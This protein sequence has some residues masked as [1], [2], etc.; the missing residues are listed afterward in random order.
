MKVIFD[1]FTQ[2]KNEIISGFAI[3]MYSILEC[4]L[5]KTTRIK[6]SSMLELILNVIKKPFERGKK[7]QI[8][9]T[10]LGTVGNFEL[11]LE[12]GKLVIITKASYD[13]GGVDGSLNLSVD[14]SVILDLI[15]KAI[16][17]Q[18]D[19]AVIAVMKAALK[20]L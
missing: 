15:A 17:G 2:H 4:W 18:V 10:N 5:G 8:V 13:K 7:M 11:K 20:S 1:F 19:D 12:G 16:P 9:N 14:S 3:F 6:S